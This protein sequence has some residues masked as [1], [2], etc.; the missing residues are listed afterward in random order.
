MVNGRRVPLAV[1]GHRERPVALMVHTRHAREVDQLGQ[2]RVGSLLPPACPPQRRH[3]L[4]VEVARD[5]QPPVCRNGHR[6]DGQAAPNPQDVRLL[7]CCARVPACRIATS[8]W[9]VAR[10]HVKVG[11]LVVGAHHAKLHSHDAAASHDALVHAFPG[12]HI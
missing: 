3:Q 5:E 10:Q 1:H 8:S 6:G 11:L 12:A 7:L 2:A 9:H 4:R